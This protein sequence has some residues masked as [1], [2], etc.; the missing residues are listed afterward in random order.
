[1][2]TDD[3]LSGALQENILTLLCFDDEFCKMVRSIIS[4][5]L[6][7]SSVYK[8]VAAVAI[9]YI[10]QF[11]E[12]I[13]EHLPDA[14]EH[15]L[16]GKDKRKAQSYQRTLDNLYLSKESVNSKYVV[17]QLHK[18]VRQQQMKSAIVKVMEAIED[19]NLDQAEVEMQHGL[20][21]QVGVF[22]IGLN[23]SDTG[24]ALSFMDEIETGINIGIE[25][26]DKRG[27]NMRKGE[28]LLIMAP[29]KRGKSWFL[30]H[31]GRQ[32]LLQ[33]QTVVHF[34]LENSEKITSQR[35]VQMF[36][37]MSKRKIDIKVPRFKVDE[38]GRL[39]D[40]YFDELERPTLTDPDMRKNLSTKMR[41]EFMKRTPLIIKQFP[42]GM[43]TISMMEAYLD[44]LERFHKIVPDVVIVDYPDLMKI[45]GMNKRI[46]TGVIYQ[47]LRGMAVQRNFA[48]VEATQVNREGMGAKKVVDTMVAEDVSKIATADAVITYSQTEQEKAMGLAR[49][50]ASNVRNDEDK[51]TVLI[52]QAYGIGQFCLDSTLLLSDYWD[53]LEGRKR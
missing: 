2:A 37:S 43:L 49:L 3:K 26:F 23:M 50:Y 31:I 5:N 46:D 1:M 29:M 33:R 32:A 53:L 34:T 22:E 36:F 16:T 8:D 19:G 35:Y 6:F 51:F 21:S 47:Q 27:V 52:S 4:A 18:F 45:D 7:E 39:T 40:I 44:G 38:M 28:A 20:R 10:D 12:A 14:L 30:T 42:T 17:S 25:E 15:V 24:S 48:L 41:K 9:D 13:K 11:G